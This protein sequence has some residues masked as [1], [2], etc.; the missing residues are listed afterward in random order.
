LIEETDV[1]ALQ[2]NMAENMESIDEFRKYHNDEGRFYRYCLE[3][4]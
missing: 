1:S 2:K 4:F 3:K